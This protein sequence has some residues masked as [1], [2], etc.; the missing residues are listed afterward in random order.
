VLRAE[1]LRVV[2]SYDADEAVSGSEPGAIV[3]AAGS[4]AMLFALI[5]YAPFL[6]DYVRFELAWVSIVLSFT[7]GFF[8]HFAHRYRCRGPIGTVL[9]LLDNSFYSAALAFSAASVEGP[10]GV[11]LGLAATH[12]LMVI[13]LP[14]RVYG[15]TLSFA[16]AMS[17]PVVFALLVGRPSAPVTLLLVCGLPIAAVTSIMTANKRKMMRHRAQ[18]SAAV[19]VSTRAAD[20]SL[21]LALGSTL[22]SL[23]NFLHELKNLQTA[24]RVNLSYLAQQSG[25]DDE[26]REALAEALE[27][28]H[29]EQRLVRETIDALKRRARPVEDRF[30]LDEALSELSKEAKAIPVVLALP[31]PELDLHGSAETLRVVIVNLVRN[32]EEAGASRVRISARLE[33][34]GHA[35]KVLVSDDGPGVPEAQRGTLFSAQLESSKSNGTGLGL[36]L[37]R[38]H[39]ELLGGS[40]ELAA[41]DRGACFAIVL[42]TARSLADGTPEPPVTD[43]AGI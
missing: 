11:G 7:G 19:G 37:C 23:G 21:Q 42:P 32:A 35:V 29:A 13:A 33:P 26:A 14:A 4:L 10:I 9:T 18:L 24:V 2:D 6:A 34:G 38:K 31:L 25:L 39:V 28:Q 16:L 8:T 22:L 27:A 12:A 41:A 15:F 17:W 1:W 30:R 3:A 40:I 5:G 36:Y 43:A 20:E